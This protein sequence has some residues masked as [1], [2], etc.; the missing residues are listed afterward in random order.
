MEDGTHGDDIAHSVYQ[1][2]CDGY[3]TVQKSPSPVLD[4]H[5]TSAFRSGNE[6]DHPERGASPYSFTITESDYC[7]SAAG[8]VDLGSS[9][10]CGSRGDR[11]TL[12][13]HDDD[14]MDED[15]EG[16][17]S[18]EPPPQ[19][20]DDVS[21]LLEQ[22]CNVEHILTLQHTGVGTY[23]GRDPRDRDLRGRHDAVRDRGQARRR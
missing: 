17:L 2:I 21:R 14:D 12:S 4:R 3:G 8:E 20:S 13:P 16:D 22:C 19:R 6:S 18:S 5:L 23:R 7:Q 11:E 10:D 1:Q 9:V 15:G